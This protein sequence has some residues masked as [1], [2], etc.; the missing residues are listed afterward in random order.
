[1]PVCDIN[2]PTVSL[3]LYLS[4]VRLIWNH[5]QHHHRISTS[6]ALR[7]NVLTCLWT[8]FDRHMLTR[9]SAKKPRPTQPELTKSVISSIS[10][11]VGVRFSLPP[12]VTKTLSAPQSVS[13][14]LSCRT[15]YSPSILTPP[16][17]QYFSS[18]FSSM[19]LLCSGSF[20]Y[21][22]IMNLQ[23]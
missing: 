16:T 17:L 22:S 23:K 8:P 7:F 2:I 21:G 9:I 12:S 1:M 15:C 6:P 11:G 10:F 19:N 14:R 5:H 20:R 13:V 18:T 4:N 3:V